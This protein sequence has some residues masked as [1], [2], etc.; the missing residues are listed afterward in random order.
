MNGR[1]GQQIKLFRGWG[2]GGVLEK[3]SESYGS[4]VTE[5]CDLCEGFEIEFT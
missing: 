5:T 1:T 3:R 4:R 2:A